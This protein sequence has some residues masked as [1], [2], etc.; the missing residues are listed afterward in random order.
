MITSNAERTTYYNH[1][2]EAA[3]PISKRKE[4]IV[5]RNG[6]ARCVRRHHLPF[7]IQTQF[8]QKMIA[9]NRFF[10]PYKEYTSYWGI[11]TSLALLGENEYHHPSKVLKKLSEIM[12]NDESRDETGKTAW[13]KFRNRKSRSSEG[14]DYVGRVLQN[15]NVLQRLG[16]DDP[17][18]LKLVQLGACID[19]KNG[20]NDIPLLR[21]RTGVPKGEDVIPYNDT[22]KRKCAKTV[23]SM[24]SQISF[25]DTDFADEDQVSEDVTENG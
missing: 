24:P 13:D 10:S 14:L 18:G 2:S 12:S 17:Y 8:L 11:T 19:I 6:K 21:L 1:V 22:K 3:K 16:G 25:L 20:E 15:C 4:T 7:H 5:G 23:D 9:E